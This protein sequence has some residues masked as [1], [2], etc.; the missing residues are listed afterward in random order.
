MS[1]VS[2]HLGSDRTVPKKRWVLKD[3]LREELKKPLEKVISEDALAEELKAAK[4]IVSIGDVCSITLFDKGLIPDIAIVDFKSSRIEREELKDKIKKIGERVVRVKNPA[5]TITGELWNAIVESYKSKKKVRIEVLG[6]ED[7]AALAC[8]A[9]A[10]KD[11]VVI[12]GIPN[13]GIA[14]VHV[15]D[16]AKSIVEDVLRKMEE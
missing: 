8:I 11:T 16:K 15:D 3:E 7:L 9:L 14:V 5:G 1:M 4:K 10:P 12:Y 13:T 6:E 2:S